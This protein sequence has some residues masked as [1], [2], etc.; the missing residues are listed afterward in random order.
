MQRRLRSRQDACAVV[1]C[2]GITVY[3]A[4]SAITRIDA[5]VVVAGV[6]LCCEQGLVAL[7]AYVS[8][9]QMRVRVCVCV[10]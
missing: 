1:Q 5:F 3:G 9:A 7:E 10:C 4:V 2:D 8:I 6:C